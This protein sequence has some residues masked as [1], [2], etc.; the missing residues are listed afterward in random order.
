MITISLNNRSI[1]LQKETNLMQLLLDE[2]ALMPD[3]AIAVNNQFIPKT[4]YEHTMLIA[5]DA[6]DILVPMQGG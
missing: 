5:G 6:I 1:T 4:Q 2:Q 3:M